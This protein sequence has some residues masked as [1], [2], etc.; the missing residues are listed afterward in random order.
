[1][2]TAPTATGAVSNAP[3][4]R[5][6]TMTTR[7]PRPN[8][9]LMLHIYVLLAVS[10]LALVGFLLEPFLREEEAVM[11]LMARLERYPDAEIPTRGAAGDRDADAGPRCCPH[12]GSEVERGYV[13]CGNCAGPLPVPA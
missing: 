6:E 11:P 10:G 2:K 9:E 13:F 8:S 4:G 5:R 12:C 1:V 7:Q 3:T